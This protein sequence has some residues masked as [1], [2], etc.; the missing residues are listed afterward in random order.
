MSVSDVVVSKPGGVTTAESLSKNLPMIIV[1]P[2]PGQE[3]NNA[4]YLT[5]KGAAIKIDD[6]K[7]INLIVEDLIENPLK[8]KQF[9]EAASL[10]GKPNASLDVANL[11]LRLSNV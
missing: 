10:I 11:L 6:P 2:I 9:S 5:Q 1:K 7:Q 3:Q 4:N 8:L